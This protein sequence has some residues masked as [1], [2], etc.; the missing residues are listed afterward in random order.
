MANESVVDSITRAA[1]VTLSAKLPD[2]LDV[3]EFADIIAAVESISSMAGRAADPRRRTA[4]T[5]QQLEG[6]A[7]PA[8]EVRRVQYGSDFA[9]VLLIIGSGV[10][11]VR[12]VAGSFEGVGRALKVIAEA[13]VANE[14]RLEKRDARLLRRQQRSSAAR[15]AKTFEEHDRL[16]REGRMVFVNGQRVEASEA[17]DAVMPALLRQSIEPTIGRDQPVEVL[18]AIAVLNQYGI[19]VRVEESD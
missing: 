16:A 10:A 3:G 13:G 2:D 18:N 17:L 8:I 11:A 4:R 9:L 7:I 19:D 12:L 15:V 5:R 14:T 1:L 6:L